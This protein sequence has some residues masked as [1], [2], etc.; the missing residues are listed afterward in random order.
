LF[1]PKDL[2]VFD[3]APLWP[4]I[5]RA[6]R[7]PGEWELVAAVGEASAEDAER[8]LRDAVTTIVGG[9]W[10]TRRVQLHPHLT[11]LSIRAAADNSRTPHRGRR[12]RG[13]ARAA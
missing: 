5:Q 4:V 8:W 10:E 13:R 9:N 2:T 11:S 6:L 7:R 12:L 1:W 3:P